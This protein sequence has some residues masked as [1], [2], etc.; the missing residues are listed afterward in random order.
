MYVSVCFTVFLRVFFSVR[1]FISVRVCLCVRK[2]VYV[3]LLRGG[4]ICVLV[5]YV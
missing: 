2:S 1:M 4:G 5:C 3:L